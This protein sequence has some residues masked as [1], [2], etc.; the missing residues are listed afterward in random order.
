MKIAPFLFI[1]ICLS[2]LAGETAKSQNTNRITTGINFV[3][4]PADKVLDVYAAS[5]KSQLIIASDVRRATHNITLQATAVSP[6][7]AR[8]M[9]EEALLKQA[10]IV[11]TRLDDKQISVTYNDQLKLEH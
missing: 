2:A 5:A 7:V 9:I 6:E 11:I 10:G 4:V 3:N 8:Q 1:I